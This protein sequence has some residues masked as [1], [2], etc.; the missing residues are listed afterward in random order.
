MVGEMS[1]DVLGAGTVIIV[2]RIIYWG[3]LHD[4]EL[5]LLSSLIHRMSLRERFPS[6]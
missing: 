4:V 2:G 5:I 6:G 1:K 3:I